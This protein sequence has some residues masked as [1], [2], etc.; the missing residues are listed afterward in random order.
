MTRS[1]CYVDRVMTQEALDEAKPKNVLEAI[2][3]VMRELPGIGKDSTAAKEQGGYAYRGIES[4]TR[5]IQ[6]LLGKYGL[7]FVLRETECYIEQIVVNSKPWTDSFLTC[8]YDV[9][10]PGGPDDKLTVGPIHVQ[11]R[12]NSDKGYNKARTQAFK[13]ALLQLFSIGDGKDDADGTNQEA[14]SRGAAP[15]AE[16]PTPQVMLGMRIKVLPEADRAQVKTFCES[17][18]ISTIPNEWSDE[19]LKT[20]GRKVEALESLAAG[21]APAPEVPPEPEATDAGAGGEPVGAVEPPASQ[22]DGEVVRDSLLGGIALY[23]ERLD[24]TTFPVYTAW[25]TEVF[26]DESADITKFDDADL[27]QVWRKLEEI[28]TGGAPA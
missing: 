5:H 25:L 22:S 2:A 16:P 18:N 12:D 28:T 6:E 21:N 23:E 27:E 4:I 26:G 17:N 14:D 10:G 8:E 7:V 15:P 19:D 11:G 20:L 9:Y 13:Y 1:L 3:A 24:E